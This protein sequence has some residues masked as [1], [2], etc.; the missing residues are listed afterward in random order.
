MTES[1]TGLEKTD[2]ANS[3]WVALGSLAAVAVA[4]LFAAALKLPEPAVATMASLAA[5]VVPAG[6]LA[7][8]QLHRSRDARL[9]DL[10]VSSDVA[11]MN[12]VYVSLVLA[13][14][15]LLFDSAIGALF[16]AV[17][18]T[19]LAAARI[20]V[21][22]RTFGVAFSATSLFFGGPIELFAFFFAG[23]HASYYLPRTALRWSLL[24]VI[25]TIPVRV[26]IILVMS[27]ALDRAG[28]SLGPLEALFS[29]SI[30]VVFVFLA[31]WLGSLWGRRTRDSVTMARRFRRL[32]PGDRAA[33]LELVKSS[34]AS[35]LSRQGD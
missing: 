26:A 11:V 6:V 23:R 35:E 10:T 30:F 31:I 3:V 8:Q 5:G 24:A 4:G 28:L 13:S 12:P 27:R 17:I 34:A 15:V 29:Y 19:T 22:S 1:A 7:H 20:Q 18:G 9:R 16:G 32:A 14:F 25:A 33:L 2:G 21:A